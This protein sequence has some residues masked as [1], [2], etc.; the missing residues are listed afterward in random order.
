MNK[1]K[2]FFL[3]F[4][5][6]CVT[7]NA[8][9]GTAAIGSVSG[10]TIG[11]IITVPIDVTGFTNVAAITLSIQYD[12]S[13]LTP[14]PDGKTLASNINSQISSALISGYSGKINIG[15]YASNPANISSGKLC[16]LSFVYNGGSTNLTFKVNECDIQ[17][18]VL[19]PLSVTYNN[20]SVS[21]TG[22]QTPSAPTLASPADG[23]TGN[24]VN[25]NLSWNASSGATSYNI[26]VSASSD[27]STTVVNAN[28]SSTSYYITDLVQGTKY[29]W[30]V[31]ASNSAGTSNYSSTYNFTTL[32]SA[33]VPGTP[34]LI[35][36]SSGATG[37]SL[38]PSL[39]W[40]PVSGATSY[41]LQV[42]AYS[43]FY[44]QVINL[45]GITS[46]SYNITSVLM[47]N[48]VYYW[49]VSATNAAG[50]GSYATS[51]FTTT[52]SQVTPILSV[53]STTA[54][55]GDVI[56]V[57][58]NVTNFTNIGSISL[59]IQYDPSVLDFT[60]TVNWDSQFPLAQANATG[61]RITIGWFSTTPG[62]IANGKLFDLK[63]TYKGGTSA[64]NV[65]TGSGNT[66]I[67][68][69]YGTAITVA[70]NNGSVSPYIGPQ[71]PSVPI[72]LSP[73][74]GAVNVSLTPTLMWNTAS[75]ATTYNVQVSTNSSFT[76]IVASQSGL[77]STSFTTPALSSSSQYYWRVSATNSVGSSN[78]SEPWSF[79][80]PMQAPATPV[81]T[82]PANG[83]T[84]VSL[85][86]SLTW[87]ASARAASYN[88]VIA[89]NSSFTSPVVNASNVTLTTYIPSALNPSTKYYWKVSATNSGGTS[90]FSEVWNF[91]TGVPAVPTA[92]LGSATPKAGDTI[93]I[94]VNVANFLSIG[95]ISLNIQ[96]DPA[97]L[98]YVEVTNW[99]SQMSGAF[100]NGTNGKAIIGWFALTPANAL[101]ISSGKLADIK[102]IYLGGTSALSFMQDCDITDINSASISVTYSG[103]SVSPY[104]GPQPPAAP[105]LVSPSNSATGIS[106]NPSLL[107][108]SSTGADSYNVLVATDA[109]F[110]NVVFSISNVV[111]STTTVTTGLAGYTKYY[112]KVNAVNSIGTS[113]FSS[114]W[115]FTTGAQ[116][117]LSAPVLSSPANGS[118]GVS[119]M[120]TL[121]WNP[122][123]GATLYNLQIATDP[124]FNNI[125]LTQNG[126]SYTG[127]TVF[128]LSNNMTYYWR[129]NA[130]NGSVISPYSTVWSF[131][132]GL[133]APAVPTLIYPANNAT[134]VPL[135]ITLSWNASANAELYDVEV[136]KNSAFTPVVVTKTNQ[137]S[138]SVLVDGLE[139]GTLYYWRVKAKNSVGSSDYSSVRNFTTIVALPVAPALASPANGTQNAPTNITFSWN[140]VSNADNYTFQIA[141]NADFTLN[142]KTVYNITGT[143]T[144]QNLD[145]NTVYYWKVM[146][147]N[148][149]GTGPASTVWNL[150][151]IVPPPV[152]PVTLTPADNAVK[153][154]INASL[155]WGKANYAD[156]YGVMVATDAAFSNVVVNASNITDTVY[157]LTNL[158]N[159]QKYYWKVNAV[160][161]N[162]ASAYSTAKTFTT[163]IAKPAIPTLS[164][165]ANGA[166][167]V[168]L[169]AALT[170]NA[171]DR[172]SSYNVQVSA[173]PSFATT[174]I[175]QSGIT[176]LT[177]SLNG[178]SGNV[179]YYWRVNAS[180]DGGTSEYSSA[181]N[182]TTIAVFKLNGVV[183]YYNKNNTPLTEVTVKLTSVTSGTMLSTTTG[184]D[185]S[186]LI[187]GVQPGKYILS[188]SKTGNWGGSN[189]ADALLIGKHFTQIDT[190]DL[191]QLMAADVS[192]NYVVNSSD[193]FLV[194][195]KFTNVITSFP[196]NKPDWLFKISTKAGI[197]NI[198]FSASTAG[199][200]TITVSTA[201]YTANI[202]ALCS[203]DPN[204][205]Y[206]PSA[207]EKI[208]TGFALNKSGLKKV[209]NKEVFEAPVSISEKVDLG[210]ISFKFTYPKDM[211][212]FKGISFN[213]SISN[214][215]V[216]EE[217]GVIA[218]SWANMNCG[219]NVIID[220]NSKLFALKFSLKNDAA[221]SGLVDIKMSNECEITDI[222]GD[223]LK[224]N[225][226]LPQVEVK[227]PDAYILEQ[228]YPNPFNPSTVIKYSVPFKSQVKVKI[229]NTLGM[230]V[231][232][233][234][235]GV[236]ENGTYEVSFNASNL[237]SGIYLY[238]IEANSLEGGKGFK[239]VKKM[240][241]IK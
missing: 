49:R 24:P 2:L 90:A 132:T 112:W 65:I 153:I 19:N 151:T 37:V 35:S 138:T 68:D 182:F 82:A 195:Q 86:P 218:I 235:N 85:I 91:T 215:V 15:W 14:Y 206:T 3:I 231:R 84:G 113:A 40:S 81:L 116:V 88:I 175:N 197:K 184:A 58:V 26:K 170:W 174:L 213:K 87:G 57:P 159:N 13:V 30:K 214:A 115:S 23:S 130:T 43:S 75:G 22:V 154:A 162:S 186:Y 191:L 188:A 60:G 180:N 92:S 139:N 240:V 201:D 233:L 36:P 64:L 4:L 96:Y 127:Y 232:E 177:L 168:A 150:K 160:N 109:S 38:T 220:A 83:A 63:F 50:T 199:N 208:S 11:S 47:P 121:A 239:S 133:V 145:G 48:T 33:P 120:P 219:K 124:L 62:S 46:T 200:D 102:F 172:A 51:G 5:I 237:A 227:L 135:S 167:G 203:G 140:A 230:V 136:S 176:A 59:L 134:G 70:Y 152:V 104:V 7:G 187:N 129:V 122:V 45:T 27:F 31:N 106:T 93:S 166:S 10:A 241:L 210:S 181:F 1:I 190:L 226:N 137:S 123:N 55:S 216:N 202:Y 8:Q 61:N 189:S 95:A 39:T 114:V 100:G 118:S 161:A 98:Q 80:T 34:T 157:N 204:K 236:M 192:N 221:K 238:S 111:G 163:I 72:L 148:A 228:N 196:N 32:T 169:D 209:T 207:L 105:V 194:S 164:L 117:S 165:P 142:L 178:L 110:T 173:D 108:Q 125:I 156:T 212:D 29:Y 54:V 146:A 143:Q 78:Y 89:T 229:Y 94:P 171:A 225:V 76:N 144:T 99:N 67:G 147:N 185:G 128:D 71:P 56:Y 17:N 101:N 53:G 205:S 16:D 69:P 126:I 18:S 25:L 12:Q 9:T 141:N 183:S 66:E 52:T 234:V 21:G 97:V 107:W 103:G 28:T 6:A 77:T 193:A 217:N 158:L 79:S 41:N 224:S 131:N 222:N 198:A 155:V 149:A 42:S 179:K 223:A 74:N 73:S 20:G 119:L 211:V 44:S